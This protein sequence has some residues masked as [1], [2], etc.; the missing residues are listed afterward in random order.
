MKRGPD[1]FDSTSTDQLPW[2]A[3]PGRRSIVQLQV[4]VLAPSPTMR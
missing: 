2:R 3:V 1:E 4:Y